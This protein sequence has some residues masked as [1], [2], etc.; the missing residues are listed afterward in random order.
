MVPPPRAAASM[1]K[2]TAACEPNFLDL[3][4]FH[5]MSLSLMGSCVAGAAML[6]DSRAACGVAEKRLGQCLK[7][8]GAQ[9]S[10]DLG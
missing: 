2:L 9:C 5:A 6:V 1:L 4:L 10:D 7:R 8:A 3:S